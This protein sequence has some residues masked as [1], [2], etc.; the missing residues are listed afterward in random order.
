[1][2]KTFILGHLGYHSSRDIGMLDIYLKWYE[3]SREILRKEVINVRGYR[4]ISKVVVLG[5]GGS[6]I[7]GDVL[8]ALSIDNQIVTVNVVKDFYIPKNIIDERTFVLSISYSGN[9][10]ETINA[11]KIALAKTNKIGIVTSGGELLKM[12]IDNSLPYITVVEGLV[13]R[14][15]FPMMLIASLKLLSSCGIQLVEER[16]IINALNVLTNIDEGLRDSNN[17]FEFLKNSKIPTIVAT[18]RYQALAIRTKNELNENAKMLARVE[19]APELFHNDIVGWEG[20]QIKDRTLIINS[21]IDYEN[22]L[23]EFYENY[24][25]ENGIETY[26]LQLRGSLLERY[27]YG[28]LVVGLTSIKLANLRGVDPLQT[29]SI[30][31]YKNM[32]KKISYSLYR[33]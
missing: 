30:A 14:A 26:R 24:L 2:V 8:S 25:Q 31:M 15:A 20:T 28:S 5:M 29:K 6:G 17:L 11:T 21:D 16:D 18:T 22:E 27:L 13:P 10:L 4:D 9:T 12:A 7:V 3:Y 19:I 1:M 23:L 32:L 33:Y